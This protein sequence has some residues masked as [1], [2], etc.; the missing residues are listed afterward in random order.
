MNTPNQGSKNTSDMVLVSLEPAE[1]LT[2]ATFDVP[3]AAF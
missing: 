2:S 3:I 1:S